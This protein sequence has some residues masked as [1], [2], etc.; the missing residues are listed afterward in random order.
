EMRVL[1]SGAIEIVEEGTARFGIRKLEL[2]R[3]KDAGGESFIFCIND[4]RVF[5]KGANWIPSDSFVPRV[6][7]EKYQTLLT[8]ARGAHMNMLRVWG[9][10]I[11]ERGNFYELCDELGIL[12]WQDFMFAC[13]A[14]PEYPKFIANV[15]LEVS[16][17]I[18]QLRNHP[19]IVLWCGNNENEWL[20]NMETRRSSREMP[21]VSL[22]E[23]I[24]PEI[25][26]EYD[27]TRPYWQSSP[28]GGEDSNN[29]KEGDRHQWNIWSNWADP[30][31]VAKDRG[32]FLSEFGFQAPACL[33]TWKKFLADQDLWPQSPVFEHHNKQ[34]EGSERLHRFL[35]GYVK[36][37]RDFDDF[38]YKTQIVQA[39]ALK[40][41]VEH[42]R[43]EKFHT[44]GTLFWQLNDCWPVSSWAVIDSELQP[45]AAYWYARRFFAPVL[46]SFKPA[47][48]FVE[49]WATNDTLAT[50]EAELA[51]E[52][53]C[54]SGKISF[55]RREP[56]F[57]PANTSLRL[58][59]L[60][61]DEL[62][63][64]NPRQQYLRGRLIENGHGVAE[65]RYFF[66]R[67]KHLELENPT[68]DCK[69]E[70]IDGGD[71]RV[72][73]KTDRF[74]KDLALLSPS[75]G[76]ILADNFFDLEAEGEATIA[77]KS[78]PANL[79][80]KKVDL[81]WKWLL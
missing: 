71:W 35:A 77:I 15:R 36:T 34:V 27:S 5:C 41:M 78:S 17:V 55:A 22:F 70:K 69:L 76:V 9:G 8:M 52:V 14:Y 54:F 57:I 1:A 16:S 46:L 32:R 13:G 73:V 6:S 29:E 75:F 43:R 26:A 65:N 79:T 33:D 24:I 53:L 80:L 45:K 42:W 7:N 74:V 31:T 58:V 63:E 81:L 11:Y 64:L 39:E 19:C 67:F 28:F 62:L 2:L 37:P 66:R 72:K 3:E 18:K 25:C 4:V 38:I 60:A 47:A 61:V 51:F 10:G 59:A 21:G 68:L 49:I 50:L 30:A 44:A 20:W 12:V 23:K 56:V 40:T 48:K